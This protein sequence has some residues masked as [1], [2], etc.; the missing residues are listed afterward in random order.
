MNKDKKRNP[1][2]DE[3]SRR[4]PN[5]GDSWAAFN[6]PR[7]PEPVVY[8]KEDEWPRP[9]ERTDLVFAKSCVPENWSCTKPGTATVPASDFGQFKLTN[10]SKL[11]DGRAPF[12]PMPD[13]YGEKAKYEI[14][15]IEHIQ[16]GGAVYDVD[17]LAVM[18][19]KRHVEIHK[20]NKNGY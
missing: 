16:Q 10:K 7:E 6:P 1:F 20:E 9:K 17:N 14:H 3:W 8:L 2:D 13:H 18:T 12:A 15:H 19:P 11:M 5:G 4:L